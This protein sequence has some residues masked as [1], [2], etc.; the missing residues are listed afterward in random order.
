MIKNPFRIFVIY[1]DGIRRKIKP[2]TSKILTE[3]SINIQ[4]SFQNFLIPKKI[5][6]QKGKSL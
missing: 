1:H 3:T 2:E 6:R 5:R 4:A